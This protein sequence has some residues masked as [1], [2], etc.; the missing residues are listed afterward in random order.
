MIIST[1]RYSPNLLRLYS[2]GNDISSYVAIDTILLFGEFNGSVRLNSWNV[3]IE[4]E[5]WTEYDIDTSSPW[6]WNF[7]FKNV[8]EGFSLFYWFYSIGKKSGWP[9]ENIPVSPEYDTNCKYEP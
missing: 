4:G 8:N 1:F 2:N 9:N 3:T 5:A 6:I 7:N